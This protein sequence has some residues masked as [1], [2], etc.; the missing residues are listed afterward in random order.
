MKMDFD[1]M[2]KIFSVAF[3][4]MLAA[5]IPL[6]VIVYCLMFKVLLG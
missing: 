2:D 3:I 1:I 5:M 6:I 4:L